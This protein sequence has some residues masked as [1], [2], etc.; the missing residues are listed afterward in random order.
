MRPRRLALRVAIGL[1]LVLAVALPF[2]IRARGILLPVDAVC[3]LAASAGAY[4][5]ARWRRDER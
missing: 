3:V 2:R 1:L 4:L 5:D